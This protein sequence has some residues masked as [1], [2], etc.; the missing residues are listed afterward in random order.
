MAADHTVLFVDDDES[1]V[2]AFADLLRH[3]DFNVAT[4]SK[5]E[6]GFDLLRAQSI[7]LAIVDESMP[8]ILG[9]DFLDEAATLSPHTIRILLTS[10]TDEAEAISALGAGKINRYLSKPWDDQQLK[11]TIREA[12]QRFDLEEQNR[13]LASELQQKNDELEGL[14]AE[15]ERKIE[16]RT[17]LLRERLKELESRDRIAQHILTIHTLSETL[18]VILDIMIEVLGFDRAVILLVDDGEVKPAAAS[19]VTA[20]KARLPAQEVEQMRFS[21]ALD[22]TI[23]QVV[24]SMVDVRSEDEDEGF[25]FGMVPMQRAGKLIGMIEFDNHRTDGFISDDELQTMSRLALPVAVAIHDA[26]IHQDVDDWKGHLDKV[27]QEMS[28]LRDSA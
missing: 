21:G 8:E 6:A 16:E 18:D 24:E 4:A 3:E 11:M 23:G 5:A 17:G 15:L 2:Q 19:G 28:E 10:S 12:L 20:P 26:L 13:Q 1:I 22:R 9:E 7:S 14:N 25:Q 27:F